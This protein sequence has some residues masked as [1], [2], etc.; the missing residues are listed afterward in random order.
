VFV[1]VGPLLVKVAAEVPTT[2][3]SSFIAPLGAADVPQNVLCPFPFDIN[4]SELQGS[5]VPVDSPFTALMLTFAGTIPRL[6]ASSCVI[7]GGIC[8]SGAPTACVPAN[9]CEKFGLIGWPKTG[10]V[11]GFWIMDM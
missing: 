5:P 10:P 1:G 8:T 3:C 11:T 2:N 6:Y 7:V 9:C 4:S